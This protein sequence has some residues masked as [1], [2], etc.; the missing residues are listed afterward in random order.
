MGRHGEDGE[1]RRLGTGPAAAGDQKTG[2]SIPL[3]CCR[4]I[5][6]DLSGFLSALDA[7]EEKDV[8]SFLAGHW[9]E[10]SSSLH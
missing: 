4:F 1:G 10:N 6:M 7:Q 8:N 3:T 5:I 9:V 2:R